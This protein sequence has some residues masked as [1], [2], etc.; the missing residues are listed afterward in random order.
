MYCVYVL[1]NGVILYMLKQRF[2]LLKFL[3]NWKWNQEIL[4]FSFMFSIITEK[5][6]IWK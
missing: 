6:V 2:L 4:S 3:L 5:C 1:W